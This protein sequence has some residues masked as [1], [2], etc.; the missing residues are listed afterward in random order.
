MNQL[1]LTVVS[2]FALIFTFLLSSFELHLPT[3]AI[4]FSGIVVLYLAVVALIYGKQKKRAEEIAV[5]IE[6]EEKKELFTYEVDNRLK[7][8]EEANDLFG[9]SIKPTDMFRLVASRVNELIPNLT[10]VLFLA[11]DGAEKLKI[12]YADGK[13][14]QLFRHLEINTLKGNAGKAFLTRKPQIDGNL[15][16]EKNVFPEAVLEDLSCAVAVPLMRDGKIFGVLQ[17]YGDAIK[18]FNADSVALLEAVAERVTPLFA[19]SLAHER[20]LSNALTDA[21]TNLPNERAFYL[22]LENQLAESQRYRQ[23]R[24]LTILT[25]DLSN[26]AEINKK[27]GHATGDRVLTFAGQIIKAQLRD[28][29]F[30]ARS[31]GDEFWVVLPTA[32]EKISDEVTSRIEKSFVTKPFLIANGEKIFLKLNFGSATFGQDGEN[33]SELLQ[34]AIIRKQQG[35]H[36]AE[37]AKVIFFP[38]DYVN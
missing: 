33:A 17:L 31:V 13:N 19:N 9:A 29:D 1:S 23:E 28:M 21:L 37:A 25:I 8:L 30:L 11:V 27:Y 18:R 5:V 24:A 34:S 3:K 2:L 10:C 20:S 16:L 32:S 36:N 6:A 12:E 22:V 38:R 35:K 4:V 26:F 14:A 7:A 15:L